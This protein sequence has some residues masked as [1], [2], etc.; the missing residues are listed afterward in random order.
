MP[1]HSINIYINIIFNL[2]KIVSWHNF[3]ILSF[4]TLRKGVIKNLELTLCSTFINLLNV[5]NGLLLNFLFNYNLK[6]H[7]TTKYFIN[8]YNRCI[9]CV[10]FSL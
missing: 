4:K 7:L 6:T 8:K 9:F 3:T 5:S 2:V 10:K 1:R